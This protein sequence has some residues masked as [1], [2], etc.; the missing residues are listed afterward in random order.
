MEF[1]FKLLFDIPEYSMNVWEFE[2]IP[3]S[4]EIIVEL[5]EHH[6]KHVVQECVL[7]LE[8]FVLKYVYISIFVNR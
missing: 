6:K 2:L 7:T 3:I 8:V 5:Q 4:R 1:F